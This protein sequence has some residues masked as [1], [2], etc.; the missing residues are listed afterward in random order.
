MFFA[1]LSLVS[2][3]LVDWFCRFCRI[4]LDVPCRRER[5]VVVSVDPGAFPV[6]ILTL[7]PAEP[8]A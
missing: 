3:D 8:V 5:S 1:I 7:L 2:G 6:F 4:E